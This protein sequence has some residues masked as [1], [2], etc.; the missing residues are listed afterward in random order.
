MDILMADYRIGAFT[1]PGK[2]ADADPIVVYFSRLPGGGNVSGDLEKVIASAHQQVDIAVE[3]Q[4]LLMSLEHFAAFA[5][6]YETARIDLEDGDFVY[7]QISNGF[8]TRKLWLSGATRPDEVVR[9]I[10]SCAMTFATPPLEGIVVII[11]D[12]PATARRLGLALA[13]AGA[14]VFTTRTSQETVAK[15]RGLQPRIV[16]M[17]SGV[18]PDGAIAIWSEA[19]P[20][21]PCHVM[22][23]TTS[24]RA[25]N[26]CWVGRCRGQSRLRQSSRWCRGSF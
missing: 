13:Q 21:W 4:K 6:I 14:A 11:H 25:S 15:M 26:Q 1:R 10:G 18:D 16:V 9:I 22:S 2:T 7:G 23:S 5:E 24:G 17:D 20:D 12:E 8:T 19:R 3:H